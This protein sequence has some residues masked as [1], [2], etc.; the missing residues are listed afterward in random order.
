M[1]SRA[2]GQ[3]ID[4]GR[5]NR[6]Q[7]AVIPPRMTQWG[8]SKSCYQLPDQKWHGLHRSAPTRADSSGDAASESVF[9]R[10][11]YL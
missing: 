4:R 2:T 11:T 8:R 6:N 9:N 3:G 7:L 10:G 1:A 5:L